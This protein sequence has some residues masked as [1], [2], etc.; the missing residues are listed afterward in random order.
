MNAIFQSKG[1]SAEL[2]AAWGRGKKSK[3]TEA[4]NYAELSLL[5]NK[6][7][8]LETAWL[9]ND[10]FGADF[11]AYHPDPSKNFFLWVQLKSRVTIKK[12]YKDKGDLN[13]AFK[14][15]SNWYIIPHRILLEIVPDSWLTSSS[16]LDKG[17]YHASS[18]SKEMLPKLA[19]YKI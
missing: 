18:P 12:Q 5:L 15:E 13:I 11:V 6:K 9:K 3:K 16:W 17:F 14:H 2:P 8:G 7:Y 10:W 19:P 1:I 4:L